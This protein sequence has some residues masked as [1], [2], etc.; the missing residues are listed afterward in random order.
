MVTR[1]AVCLVHRAA[2]RPT[3]LR[4]EDISFSCL[5]V[6]QRTTESL[7]S[8]PLTECAMPYI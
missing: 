3:D 6:V 7:V 1:Y 8:L 4:S 5:I 2:I